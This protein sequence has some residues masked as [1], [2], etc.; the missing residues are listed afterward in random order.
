MHV[1]GRVEQ[2]SAPPLSPWMERA[3]ELRRAGRDIIML[4]QAMVD[5]APP[6]IFCASL[7]DALR[8]GAGRLHHYTPDPGLP[9]LRAGVAAY[10]ARSFGL[11]VDAEREI[12]ITPGA[13]H[14]AYMALSVLLE[15]GDEVLLVSPWYFNHEMAVRLLGGA[16]QTVP[17]APGDGFVPSLA[18]LE[19]AW[20]PRTRALV[21]V[22]P[23]NPTGARYPEAWIEALAEMLRADPRWAE[24]WILVDQ[25]YQEIFFHEPRPSS[26]GGRPG[27]RHRAVTLGSFSKCFGLAGWRL[28]FLVAPPAFVEAAL[29]VQDSSIICA[30]HAA[31]WAL[32]RLLAGKRAMEDYLTEKRALLGARRDALLGALQGGAPLVPVEPGGACFA[33]LFLPGDRD[34]ADAAGALLERHG[35]ATV[36]G[37]CFGPGWRPCLRLGFGTEPEAR[38][39]EA[40]ARIR[41]FLGTCAPGKGG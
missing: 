30:P 39:A 35:V 10:L 24:V 29:K 34:G 15:A 37:L 28:G 12:L 26:L 38:L 33:F 2:T 36:P 13:N 5:Y 3:Q 17:A 21:L 32:A 1:A 16:V 18:A 27:L 22:N 9:E 8:R 7:A 20:T 4:A 31:Q 14:A 25:T 11:H 6:E 41:E 19:R 23:N 40:G